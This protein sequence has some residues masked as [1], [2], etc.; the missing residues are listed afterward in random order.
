MERPRGDGRRRPEGRGRALIDLPVKRYS[1][2][3]A[4]LNP[5]RGGEIDKVRPVVIVSQNEMNRHLETV[6]VCPLATKLHPRWR[7]RLPC[8]CAGKTAEIAV[9][10][11]RTLSKERLGKR[12][13]QL[14]AKAAVQLRRLITEMY[15]E[16]P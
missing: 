9:D 4:D 11:I 5:T 6:V 2:H 13:G 7:S 8:V 10:Q 3:L 15:G 16:S 14:D 1:L 12:L